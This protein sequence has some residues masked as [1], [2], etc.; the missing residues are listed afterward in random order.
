MN[1]RR[2]SAAIVL[3]TS[4]MWSTHDRLHGQPADADAGTS[5]SA[6]EVLREH[7]YEVDG[8]VRPLLFWIRKQN[9]GDGRLTWRRGPN[10]TIGYELLVGSDPARAPRQINRWGYLREESA[11]NSALM[12]GIM[13]HSDEQSVE[14]ADKSTSRT[15]SAHT[16]KA[17]RQFLTGSQA[18]V[19]VSDIRVQ[20]DLTYSDLD[21]L[22]SVAP[23]AP[24]KTKTVA[25]AHWTAPGFLTAAASLMQEGRAAVGEATK[26]ERLIRT[27]PYN[28]GLYALQLRS[29]DQI[30]RYTREGRSFGPA[31]RGLFRVLNRTTGEETPFTVVYGVE[32]D[33]TDVPLL[34]SWRPRWWLEIDCVIRHD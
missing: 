18:Q 31:I 20:K 5:F 32:G 7:R 30:D 17:L 12:F 4:V 29:I 8:R 27:Y 6:A 22:L 23:A 11:G 26:A 25:I 14:D 33:L 3:T 13:S 34:I 15:D 19:T 9:I 2:I 1:A 21:T 10:G 24:A 16:F 28:G